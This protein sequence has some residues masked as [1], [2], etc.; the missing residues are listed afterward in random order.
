MR[1]RRRA[2]TTGTLQPSVAKRQAKGLQAGLGRVLIQVP[3][4]PLAWGYHLPQRRRR[5]PEGPHDHARRT[6]VLR[7]AARLRR[8]ADT[9]GCGATASAPPREWG[10]S[11]RAP[12]SRGIS[13]DLGPGSPDVVGVLT[14]GGVGSWW[15]SRSRAPPG[16][17]DP[18]TGAWLAA[19]LRGM[20]TGVARSA[21][22]A[23]AIVAAGRAH[24]RVLR[25]GRLLSQLDMARASPLRADV[26]RAEVARGLRVRHLLGER[27]VLPPR[28]A[29]GGARRLCG[30]APLPR[31]LAEI[32]HCRCRAPSTRRVPLRRGAGRC[33]RRR[34]SRGRRRSPCSTPRRQA[35]GATA[36]R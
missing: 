24:Y 16:A 23:R 34:H 18:E 36:P 29:G 32:V 13:S 1:E 11:P 10:A 17:C 12:R 28:L 31:P 8:A 25:G 15:A 19:E 20:V 9:S 4:G 33:R 35:S 21:D 26:Q 7:R 30:L 2:T 27:R 6:D 22:D 14:V 5:L 3:L